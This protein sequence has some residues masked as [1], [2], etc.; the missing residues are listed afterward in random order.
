[1]VVDL[2]S[3]QPLGAVTL[4]WS[5]AHAPGA[6]VEVSTDGVDYTPAATLDPVDGRT[7]HAALAVTARYVAV[8]VTGWRPGQP[9]LADLAVTR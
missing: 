7:Q 5:A 2:G 3:A 1:M 4:A 9:A 8:T 6:V